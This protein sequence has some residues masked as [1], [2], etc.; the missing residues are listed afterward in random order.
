MAQTVSVL[1]PAED[2]ARLLAIVADRNRP[3]K[4]VQRAQI[5]LCSAE[6][7]PVLSGAAGRGQPSCR[8]ALAGALHRAR[9]RRSAARQ[10]AQARPSAAFGQGRRKDFGVDLFR[11]AGR[12]HPLDR[13]RHGQR[14]W[15][16]R[17]APSRRLWEA[18]RLQPHR[19]RTYKRSS[20]PKFAE[21]V[22]HVVGL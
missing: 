10:D 18:H 16:Y 5:I 4:H 6:R 19:V 1:P 12:G 22:E 20:D 11:A 17:C 7:L 15:A 13:T 14:P 21:K 9:R 3:L 2:R 8:L